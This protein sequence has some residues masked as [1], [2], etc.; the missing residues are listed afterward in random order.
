MK[1]KEERAENV[2][3]IKTQSPKSDRE[4]NFCESANGDGTDYTSIMAH[5]VVDKNNHL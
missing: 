1:G 3:M 4:G 2:L 5:E